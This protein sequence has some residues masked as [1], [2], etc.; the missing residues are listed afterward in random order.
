VRRADAGTQ[1]LWPIKTDVN[2]VPVPP[3]VRKI[4]SKGTAVLHVWRAGQWRQIQEKAQD[5]SGFGLKSQ[6]PARKIGT[7]LS[8]AR[9]CGRMQSAPCQMSM[10][11]EPTLS[12][13]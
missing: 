13:S 7:T 9:A 5:H 2:V 4:N 11:I 3:P 1:T 10:E 6:T 8:R 12:M